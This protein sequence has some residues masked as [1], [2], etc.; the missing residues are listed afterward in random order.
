MYLQ[1]FGGAFERIWN[2][3]EVT[4]FD[5]IS[6]NFEKFKFLLAHHFDEG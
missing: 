1:I 4:F 6:Y 3:V 5:L 2:L